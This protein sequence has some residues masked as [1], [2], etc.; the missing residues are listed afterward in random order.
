MQTA[1]SRHQ[2]PVLSA[3]QPPAAT[4]AASSDHGLQLQVIPAGHLTLS[5]AETLQ[6]EMSEKVC[7]MTFPYTDRLNV[8][9]N[10]FFPDAEYAD[11]GYFCNKKIPIPGWGD[12][13]LEFKQEGGQNPPL[14]YPRLCE[15]GLSMYHRS[16]W[17]NT[18]IRLEFCDIT[19]PCPALQIWV[20]CSWCQR[21][22]FPAEGH[23][24]SKKHHKGL[25]YLNTFGPDWCRH[26]ARAECTRWF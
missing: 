18:Y 8:V 2:P 11:L 17:A 22:Q 4:S 13:Y 9:F 15:L 10:S 1:L 6:L 20:W 21:F 5:H 14:M 12:N 23:R 25:G 16:G 7:R 24:G 3:A 26:R 19:K